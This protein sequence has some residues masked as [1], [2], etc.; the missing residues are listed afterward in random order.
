MSWAAI[1]RRAGE[2]ETTIETIERTL[3]AIR[4]ERDVPEH[5]DE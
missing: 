5:R 4:E 1:F 2:R 3:A